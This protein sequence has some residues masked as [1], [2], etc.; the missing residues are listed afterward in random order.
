MYSVSSQGV[1][2]PSGTLADDSQGIS[3]PES[4]PDSQ[5]ISFPE[6]DPSSGRLMVMSGKRFSCGREGLDLKETGDDGLGAADR[7]CQPGGQ[8]GFHRAEA[9]VGQ[10]D[11]GVSV[12][13]SR[14]RPPPFLGDFKLQQDSGLAATSASSDEDPVSPPADV[15]PRPPSSLVT[16]NKYSAMGQEKRHGRKCGWKTE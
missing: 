14:L 4:D 15:S 13:E 3:F 6:S 7:G 2:L 9:M 5:G 11:V 12:A 16:F 10:V 8:R 1:R